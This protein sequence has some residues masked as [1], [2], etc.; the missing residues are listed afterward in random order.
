MSEALRNLYLVVAQECNLACAYCYA[1]GGG[2]G[3]PAR[4]MGWAIL[5]RGLERLLPMA[6]ER[7]TLSFFGGEPLLNFPLMRQAIDLADRMASD[8]GRA[9]S[10]ALTTNGTLLDE[11]ILAVLQ[12]RVSHLAI[13]LDGDAVASRGRVFRDG[14]PAFATIMAN[15]AKLRARGIP[16][17]LRA[18]VTPDNVGRAAETVE[19]LAGLGSASVR[20]LPAQGVAW[21]AESRRR[22]GEVMAEINRRGLRA[23]LAGSQPQACEHAYRLV[24]HR[25]GGEAAARPCLAGGGVLALAADGLVYPCEHFVG[26]A[27]MAMGHVDDDEFPGPRYREI[28]GRFKACTAPARPRCSVC[29]IRDACGG[30]CYAEA[31]HATGAISR[32][33]AEYCALVRKVHRAMEPELI[34]GLA[35]PDG[36]ERLREAIGA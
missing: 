16:F 15:L 34:R 33:A 17:G 1:G 8:T 13:S 36:A 12:E 32:P 7:L 24:A 3:Q 27:A 31:W 28:A 19:F 18:T 11:E 6:G 9:V 35:D 10:Y 23:M 30:Q 2:F 14:A 4:H 20:L 26:V 25:T 22:L 21:P 29:A 5:R